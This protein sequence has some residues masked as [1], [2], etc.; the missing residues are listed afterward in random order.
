MAVC[1]YLKA[2][3]AGKNPALDNLSYA[4]KGRE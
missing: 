3:K 1:G 2:I 4:V